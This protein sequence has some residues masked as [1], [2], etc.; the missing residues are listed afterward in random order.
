MRKIITWQVPPRKLDV[1]IVNSG[2]NAYCQ[3]ADISEQDSLRL[4]VCIEGVFSYLA[5]NIRSVEVWKEI[6]IEMY[7]GDGEVKVI[8][9][10]CGPA[11]EWDRALCAN[12]EL[13]IRRTSF[14]AMGLFIAYDML[15]EL[16]CDSWFD[17][18]TGNNLRQYTLIY[19]ISQKS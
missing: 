15:E 1:A 10:H 14:E 11:G 7:R 6:R 17:M 3:S 16:T 18:G 5:T 9:E 19:R 12:P 2:V 8:M 13:K 4:Q